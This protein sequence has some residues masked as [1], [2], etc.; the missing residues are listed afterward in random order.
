MAIDRTRLVQSLAFGQAPA[1]GF[2]PPGTWNYSSQA[3]AWKDLS[4]AERVAEAK[5][6][7]TEAGYS[8][9]SPLHLRLLF[10]SNPSIQQTAIIVASMWRETLGI[11]TELVDE[12]YRVFLQ[13]RHD[14]IALGRCSARVEQRISTM[15][16]TFSIRCAHTPATMIPAT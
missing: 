6:L 12:E 13:S 9:S 4:D 8:P 14:Q 10:N 5:R 3:W 11:D 2:V 7:Y 16:V 1:F 15:P